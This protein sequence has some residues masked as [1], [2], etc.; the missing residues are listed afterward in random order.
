MEHYTLM[1][2]LKEE[3]SLLIITAFFFLL[4]GIILGQYISDGCM[5]KPHTEKTRDEQLTDITVSAPDDKSCSISRS[6]MNGAIGVITVLV[7]MGK[8]RHK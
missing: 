5:E 4:M 8:K 2:I 1:W 3:P 6:F 7:L